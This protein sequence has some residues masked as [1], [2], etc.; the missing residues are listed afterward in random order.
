MH[1]TLNGEKKTL[2]AQITVAEF[3]KTQ[4]YDEKAPIAIAI[5]T[6]IVPR[7]TWESHAIKD[8]DEVEIVSPMQGG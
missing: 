2:D 6:T 7:S 4:G 5:N 1:I 8:G 3:V